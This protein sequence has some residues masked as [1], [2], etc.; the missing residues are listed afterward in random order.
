[1]IQENVGTASRAIRSNWESVNGPRDVLIS[2]RGGSVRGERPLERKKRDGGG[3]KIDLVED[4]NEFASPRNLLAKN[5]R[6]DSC[7]FLFFCFHFL[8]SP[9]P[10]RGKGDENV[11]IG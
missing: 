2:E 6:I 5:L 1:M 10:P 3:G 8:L 9:F 11:D 4:V 7:D